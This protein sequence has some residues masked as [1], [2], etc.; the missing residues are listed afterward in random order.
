MRFWARGFVTRA[1]N[2]AEGPTVLIYWS[3][4]I[5]IFF[6]LTTASRKVESLQLHAK[7]TGLPCSHRT[8]VY[9]GN[10]RNLHTC[11]AHED[12]ISSI[13]F[14]AI[15]A[16]LFHRHAKFLAQHVDQSIARDPLKND[17]QTLR[18]ALISR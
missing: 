11:T 2:F 14:C 15:D 1:A 13:E 18:P 17:V 5:A 9:T 12:F 4:P 7:W 3:Y 16:P 10:R 6:V 8:T